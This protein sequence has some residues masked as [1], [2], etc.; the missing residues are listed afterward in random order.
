MGCLI[1]GRKALE[2]T[3]LEQVSATVN[4]LGNKAVKDIWNKCQEIARRV[5]CSLF[6]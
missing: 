2:Y 3:C 5:T 4:A 6:L 1:L